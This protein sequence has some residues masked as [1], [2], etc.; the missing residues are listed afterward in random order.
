MGSRGILV[1][2]SASEAAGDP[3]GPSVP[4]IYPSLGLPELRRP[5]VSFF[6]TASFCP[7]GSLS[8]VRFWMPVARAGRPSIAPAAT[9]AQEAQLSR[10]GGDRPAAAGSPSPAITGTTAE[11]A[12]FRLTLGKWGAGVSPGLPTGVRHK[13]L[14]WVG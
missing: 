11:Q 14:V 10:V 9:A 8:H 13:S 6:S 7:N 4:H 5:Q 12:P 1:S 3:P 2:L